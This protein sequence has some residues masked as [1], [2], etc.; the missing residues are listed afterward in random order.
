MHIATQ[1]KERGYV[2]VSNVFL[3]L[4]YSFANFLVGN[5]LVV[6]AVP[7]NHRTVDIVCALWVVWNVHSLVVNGFQCRIKKLLTVA[8]KN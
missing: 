5:R 4:R 3:R 1:K 7:H 2:F 8:E 6:V